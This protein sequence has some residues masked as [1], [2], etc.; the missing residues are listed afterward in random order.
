[1]TDRGDQG[2]AGSSPCPGATFPPSRPSPSGCPGCPGCPVQFYATIAST[3]HAGGFAMVAGFLRRT[4]KALFILVLGAACALPARAA[5][6]WQP[7]GPA[8]QVNTYTPSDQFH[9]AVAT[10]ADG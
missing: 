9:P 6:T 3:L 5:L 4:S 8:F 10:D 1:M 2:A 7:Q